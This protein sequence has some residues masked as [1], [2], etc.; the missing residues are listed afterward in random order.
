MKKKHL[1]SLFLPGFRFRAIENHSSIK[2]IVFFSLNSNRYFERGSF[3][4]KIRWFR[5]RSA[6]NQIEKKL[7]KKETKES[8]NKRQSTVPRI[9]WGV[10]WSHSFGTSFFFTQSIPKKKKKKKDSSK[11]PFFG[12]AY[13]CFSFN[14]H[15]EEYRMFFDEPMISFFS[16]FQPFVEGSI[17]HQPLIRNS[18]F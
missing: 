10:K 7:K 8:R 3:A 13:F 9:D 4:N 15:F 5:G 12:L 11:F 1:P 6:K 2:S 16:L 17:D 14:E 18:L